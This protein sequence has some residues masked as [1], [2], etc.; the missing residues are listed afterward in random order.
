MSFSLHTA[1]IN[2]NYITLQKFAESWTLQWEVHNFP[3][4]GS[5]SQGGG[6][7]LIFGQ[8]SPK[9]AWKWKK[10]DLKGASLSLPQ[11]PLPRILQWDCWVTFHIYCSGQSVHQSRYYKWHANRIYKKVLR[12]ERKRHADRRVASPGRGCGQ[13]DGQTRVKT[14]T[15]CSLFGCTTSYYRVRPVTTELTSHSVFRGHVPV[16]LSTGGGGEDPDQVTLPPPP[17]PPPRMGGRGRYCL[18][19]LMGGCLVKPSSWSNTIIVRFSLNSAII[20]ISLP[21]T[22]PRQGVPERVRLLPSEVEARLHE[23]ERRDEWGGDP[24]AAGARRIRRQGAGGA[25]HAEEIQDSQ[26]RYYES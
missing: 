8:I 23:A 10:L 2:R 24:G 16:R 5:N 22:S 1:I 19:M 17:T 11:P 15:C 13:T 7:S 18:V 20:L 9:T 3:D 6:V 14:L 25:L 26:K 21:A 12:R 4:G